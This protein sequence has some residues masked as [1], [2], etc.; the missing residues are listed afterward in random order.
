MATI[1]PQTN[2]SRK[3]SNFLFER[4]LRLICDITKLTWYRKIH[5]VPQPTRGA[6]KDTWC[7]KR[8]VVPQNANYQCINP[9]KIQTMYFTLIS[10]CLK[11]I[12][13]RHLRA[14]RYICAQLVFFTVN[15]YQQLI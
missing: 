7:R 10:E 9:M 2:M 15:R 5:V 13:S 8:H 6:T 14:A 3:W 1:H 4:I 11:K 12:S